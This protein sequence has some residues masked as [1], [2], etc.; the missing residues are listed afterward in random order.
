MV[1]KL[2]SGGGIEVARAYVTI[3]PKS[4]G[5]S[6]E[7]I[8]SVVDPVADAG[9]KAGGLFNTGL[10]KTLAKFA[11]PA[12][13]GAALIGI[14][15][16]G[17]S[18]FEEVQGGMNEVIKATGATGQSAKDLE[19]VYKEVAGNV[20]G[21][22][23]SIGATVGELNTRLGLQGKD[24]EA[25]SEAMMKYSKVTG[26]D[27]V[28]A[29]K[30][31]AS[32]MRNV[33]IPAEDLEQTLGKLTVAGQAAGI[34][35][36]N[37]A[38]NVTRYNAVMKQ[39]GFTT[40]EQIALMAKFEQSGA[41]T[42]SIL[43]AMKKGVANWAKDGKD[44]NV[45]FQNF[46]KGVQDGSVTAGDAVEIFGTRGGLSMYEAA[47]KGQLSFEDMYSTITG[48]SGENLDQV[49][50]DTLT[51]SE[52]MSLAWQNVKL[53]G[54]ELFAPMGEAIGNVLSNQVIPTIQNAVK[55]IGPIM[56]QLGTFYNQYIKPVLDTVVTAVA[57]VVSELASWV[58]SAVKEVGSV[59]AAVM[60]DILNIVQTVIPPA[61][62]IIR[63][64]MGNIKA[65]VVPVWNAIKPV[66]INVMHGIAAVVRTVWPI[67]T[68]V[69]KKA[70]KTIKTVIEGIKTVV[71]KVTGTF[72]KVK[73]AITK[74][75]ETARTTIQKAIDKIKGIIN[76]VK[77][78]LPHFSLPHFSVSGGKAPFGIGGK[79][80]MPKFSVKWYAEGGI[81][82]GPSLIGVGEKG[83]EA[84]IPLDPFWKKLDNLERSGGDVTI[85]N[86]ITVDGAEDPEDWAMRFAERLR[87]EV[88]MA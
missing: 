75:I 51:A 81:F 48:A 52:K 87:M 66:V 40:D 4:D 13:I 6:N 60:P 78:K 29:T 57:P 69:I 27:G 63:I 32:M 53:G 46:V 42:S 74:P 68:N 59:F 61:M 38:Q 19:K 76:K 49:Y 8:N 71:S 84:V 26:Q 64:Q 47:Q 12:A 45:E 5:T 44:A 85:N 79:G 77:L 39:M 23:N 15:K 86:T 30:D 50:N 2:A 31:V 72:N 73:T 54:A 62:E 43:N 33:G 56:A 10:G 35:V 1:S 88:R 80:S 82:D 70:V 24:L 25:A 20:V 14:G 41:D 36:G 67:I 34:D 17:F 18:A 65:V 83:T 58:G 37:L 7:V 21:D 11:A 22:F 55:A 16:A 28:K 3:I 9:E